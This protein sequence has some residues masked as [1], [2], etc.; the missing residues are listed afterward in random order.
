MVA[1]TGSGVALRESPA[2]DARIV[3][4]ASSGAAFRATAQSGGFLR[5]D[6][7]GGRPAWV[8]ERDTRQATRPAPSITEALANRPPRISL[9]ATPPLAVRGETLHLEGVVTDPD[10]VLDMYI[11]VGN[12]KLFYL[13]NRSGSTAGRLPFSTD[14]PLEGGA[15]QVL[16]VARETTDLVARR[17]IV[18]RRDNPDGTAI[19][20]RGRRRG[21]DE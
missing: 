21:D 15:N 20:T 11:F 3:A 7:G 19:P 2:S 18:V 4:E 9:A 8:A 12:R 10:R 5:V 6:L 14:V 16:I 17:H 13:S 1:V